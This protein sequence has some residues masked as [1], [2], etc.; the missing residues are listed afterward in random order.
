MSVM[1]IEINRQSETILTT[2]GRKVLLLSAQDGSILNEW[3]MPDPLSF[4]EEGGTSMH[5]DG[6]RFM[7]V[8]TQYCLTHD[9]DVGR[10]RSVGSRIRSLKW[11]DTSHL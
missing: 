11:E 8:S 2:I 10:K 7:T 4:R 6:T 5:P 1:D 9:H 3:S